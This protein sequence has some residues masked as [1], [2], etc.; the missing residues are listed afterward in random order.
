[1]GDLTLLAYDQHRAR[2]RRRRYGLRDS[3]R[4]A[5]PRERRASLPCAG[6][7]G[8]AGRIG[9]AGTAYQHPKRG[10]APP[11]PLPVGLADGELDL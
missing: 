8:I 2:R 5:P 10:R 6:Y 9:R 1:M 4:T 11:P 3:I 7:H